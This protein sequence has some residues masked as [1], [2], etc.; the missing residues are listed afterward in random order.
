MGLSQDLNIAPS[1][2]RWTL[3]FTHSMCN[4]L[5][6]MTPNSQS[7]LPHP[8]PLTT[9]AYVHGSVSVLQIGSLVS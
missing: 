2:I 4:M 5:Q 6:L 7:T 3:L 1:A 8:S 9:T